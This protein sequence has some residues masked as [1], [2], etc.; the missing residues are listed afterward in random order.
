MPDGECAV[1]AGNKAGIEN[2]EKWCEGLEKRVTRVDDKIDGL[3][4]VAIGA[5]IAGV[6]S[7]L[8]LAVNLI[9]SAI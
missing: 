2:L 3:K 7:C 9:A 4:N 5:L 6:I 8:L 1:G